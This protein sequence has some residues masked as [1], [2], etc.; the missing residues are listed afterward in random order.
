MDRVSFAYSPGRP[1]LHDMSLTAGPGEHVAI[2]G[3]T[4][5]G[6][7]TLLALLAGLYPPSNGGIKLAGRD[8]R[9]LSDDERR[10]TLGFVSQRVNLFTGTVYDNLAMGDDT[11]PQELVQRAATIAGA[12]P[13][14]RTLPHG[15]HTM[16]AA[17]THGNG[18]QLSAGQRQLM[19]LARAL[20]TK[21]AVLLLDEATAVVDGAS[22]AAFR[23]ALRDQVLPRGTAV[24]TV[25]HRLA[26]ARDADR[27]LVIQSGQIIEQGTPSV[28]L[29]TDGTFAALS[30][31]EEA[32]WDWQHD[33]DAP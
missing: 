30:A 3:R 32:G 20:T 18:V 14:I 6:K 25:A 2:V 4:G 7:S 15:Y 33:P 31:L 29:S 8:P 23:A 26:T 12:D 13:F 28:L 22:D 24:V 1:V 17:D 9:A 21:P 10:A 19:A 27:V 11:L 16:L 5:A